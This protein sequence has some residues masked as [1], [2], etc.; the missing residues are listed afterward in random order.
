MIPIIP[1][2]QQQAN[3]I[4]TKE[5]NIGLVENGFFFVLS[6]IAGLTR[7][8]F[9]T[10][11][12]KLQYTNFFGV[13]MADSG[14]GKDTAL[15]ATQNMFEDYI[16]K[17]VD[18][19]KHDFQ[20]LGGKLPNGDDVSNEPDY[21]PP[22][23]YSFPLRGSVEGM[24]RA[25]NFFN[26]TDIGSLNVVS[27]E[28]GAEYNPEVLPILTSLWQDAKADGS[29]N[30]NQKYPPI[31]DVPTNTILFGSA[32]AFH[33]NEKKHAFLEEAIES[34]FARRATF[35]WVEAGQITRIRNEDNRE[36][37]KE[38]ADQIIN[39][40]KNEKP[41]TFNKEARAILFTYAEKL[42]AENNEAPSNWA[43][44]KSSSVDKVERISALIALADL[45]AT[46]EPQHV[47]YAIDIN[48]RSFEA[49]GFILRPHA[50]YINMFKILLSNKDGLSQTELIDFGVKIKTK[51]DWEFQKSLL[52]DLAYRKN[53]QLKE[54]GVK[55]MLREFD[56]NKLD[57]MI[58][59]TSVNNNVRNPEKEVNFKKQEVGFFGEGMT[60]E[61][62]ITSSINSFCMAH[63]EESAKAPEGHRR[64]DSFI[65]GQNMIAFDI[66]EGFLLEDA[67]ELLKHYTWL[68]YTT[69]NHNKKKNDIIC[70]RFRIVMPTKTNFFVTVEQHKELYENLS[71][72]LEIPIYDVSTRN[73]S[74]LWYTNPEA[75]VHKNKGD[76][77]DVRC[78]I[79]ETEKA[80][81]ILPNIINLEVGEGDRR[82]EG[83]IKYI[84][85]N[86]TQG[87]RNA[88]I[89][90]L[91]KFTQ[92]MGGNVD[93]ITHRTNQM[94][95]EPMSEGEVNSIIRKIK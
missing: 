79:P 27:T 80:E 75:E 26:R 23:Q 59:S 14:A 53:M 3:H 49:M 20:R 42:D 86:T 22:T 29:T 2:V 87:N 4:A 34:G 40:L 52:A 8:Q 7:Q 17:Y 45:S 69:R 61:S 64:K 65:Q 28:F 94:L 68:I 37:L 56:V 76:I 16:N 91:A 78:C 83:M 58:I 89:F 30:V 92:E 66:D 82:I 31:F 50:Q 10:S 12:G 43:G 24:M 6:A 35:V 62:L 73:V 11:N 77:L 72:A 63:F 21:I 93:D 81:K 54:R 55:I 13:S 44:I 88:M 18:I 95:G 39:Q 60:I 71:V 70:D 19:V 9:I 90:R 32:S 85:I 51:A 15:K 36:T 48:E 1:I 25:G 84:L 57:R 5:V 74:R 38:Y 33:K 67:K 47:E 46:I 41:I